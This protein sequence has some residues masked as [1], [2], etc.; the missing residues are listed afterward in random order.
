MT[1]PV[2]PRDGHARPGREDHPPLA[3]DMPCLLPPFQGDM[4]ALHRQ[5]R[6]NL[7]RVPGGLAGSVGRVEF[8][9]RVTV[10]DTDPCETV[11][12]ALDALTAKP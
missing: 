7:P 2:Y 12:A 10:A 11:T 8:Q 6:P 5:G 1:V 3:P 4:D 9:P